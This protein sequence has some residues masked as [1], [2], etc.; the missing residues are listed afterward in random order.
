MEERFVDVI[1]PLVAHRQP[2][3]AIQPRQRALHHPPVSSELLA[4]VDPTAGDARG[5][6]PLPERFSAAGEVV[7]L[8]GVQLRG[9]LARPAGVSARLANRRNGVHRLLQHLGVVDVGGAEDY[10]E[11]DAP[12]VRNNMALRSRFSLIRRIRAGSLA[13]LFAGTLAESKE[14]LSQSIR[15]ASPK[16]SKSTRWS[17]SH[18]P[19]S[20]QSRRRRQHVDPDPQPISFGSISQGMPLLRTKT[21]PVR[22]ARLSMRG[23]PPLGLGGSSGNSGSMIS[24][25]S[26]DTCS[27]LMS[28]SV[29]STHQ[30]VL[31]G[32]T[33]SIEVGASDY[34][35]PDAMK[36]GGVTGWLRTAALAGAAGIPLSSHLFPE[37]SVHLLAVSPTRHWLEYVDWADPI[38]ENPLKIEDGYASTPYAAGIGMSWDVGAVQRYSVGEP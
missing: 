17:S 20:C 14:A 6:A 24:Q 18:T 35:M 7:G 22:A 5:Y 15:S 33:K 23:L 12:S 37:I 10:R 11:R 19:A 8:V 3:V 29:T 2:A 4:G 38:L 32:S 16:R 9:T 30:Q 26:S 1:A 34:V 13:P 28:V 21:M 27:L 31:Q 36:I 25:S